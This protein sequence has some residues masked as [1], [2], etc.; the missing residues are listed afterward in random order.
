MGILG[1][2]QHLSSLTRLV[3]QENSPLKKSP[4]KE[5]ARECAH[6]DKNPWHWLSKAKSPPGTSSPYLH[7]QQI[8][9]PKRRELWWAWLCPECPDMEMD[10]LRLV[11]AVESQPAQL[12]ACL[13]GHKRIPRNRICSSSLLV[14]GPGR[15]A[16]PHTPATGLQGQLRHIAI[17]FWFQKKHPWLP[18]SSCQ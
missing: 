4:R 11:R 13:L 18:G 10:K 17:G 14:L 7:L 2:S 3:L 12:A 6:R 16:L 9:I 5:G 1:T 8:K 15:L